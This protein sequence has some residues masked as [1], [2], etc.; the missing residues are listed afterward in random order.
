MSILNLPYD[1]ED[2]SVRKVL[3]ILNHFPNAEDVAKRVQQAFPY[4]DS[5][6][7]IQEREELAD[8]LKQHKASTLYTDI[9]TGKTPYRWSL[10]VNEMNVYEEGTQNYRSIRDDYV[11]Y[12]I[13]KPIRGVFTSILGWGAYLGSN[14]KTK[15]VYVYNPDFFKANI[16][17][18]YPKVRLL[19]K[20]LYTFLDDNLEALKKVFPVPRLLEEIRNEKVAIYITGHW[21]NDNVFEKLKEDAHLYDRILIK[22]HPQIFYK[23]PEL[24]AEIAKLPFDVIK[25]NFVAEIMFMLLLKNGNNISI[26][27]E[28]STACIYLRE[29]E[30]V[31]LYDYREGFHRLAFDKMRNIYLNASY[32][33]A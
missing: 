10:I 6:Q 26:F 24:E 7:V 25:E 8:L 13:T 15:H 2:K 1:F 17:S 21:L 31:K 32:S 16:P 30:N 28:S 33:F 11:K 29:S 9:D 14:R 19:K 3:F 18:V 4:W 23:N 5:V 22:I 27:H 12:P 20:E